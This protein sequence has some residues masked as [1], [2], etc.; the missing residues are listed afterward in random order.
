MAV[1]KG[2]GRTEASYNSQEKNE[3]GLS[4]ELLSG[5]IHSSDSL[6]KPGETPF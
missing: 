4:L 6:Y 2:R 1:L 5:R 3:N